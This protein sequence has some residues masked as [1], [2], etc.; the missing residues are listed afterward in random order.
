[1]EKNGIITLT[2]RIIFKDNLGKLKCAVCPKCGFAETY[3]Q[4]TS[5]I[6]KLTLN[7]KEK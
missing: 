7:N 3:I 5:K 4:D 2:F 1:M 6:K